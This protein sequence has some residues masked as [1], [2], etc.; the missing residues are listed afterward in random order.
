M[1]GLNGRQETLNSASCAVNLKGVMMKIKVDYIKN[2]Y[3][4]KIKISQ[5]GKSISP[6]NR[7][8]FQGLEKINFPD[9]REG[10]N[11]NLKKNIVDDEIAERWKKFEHLYLNEERIKKFW[12]AD[13]ENSVVYPPY[14]IVRVGNMIIKD[15][16]RN[17]KMLQK[18][19]HEVSPENIKKLMHSEDFEVDVALPEASVYIES[20]S[21]LLGCGLFENYF[22][23]TLRYVS[24]IQVY[25]NAEID[26]LIVPE[27]TKK[28]IGESL[29][30]FNVSKGQ[31]IY[32]DKI[33]RVKKLTISS[34]VALGR[35]EIS[36]QI[37]LNLREH[38]S[39]KSLLPAGDFKY[40]YIPRRNVKIR[41]IIN[42]C[43]VDKYFASIGF[44]IFDNSEYSIAEQIAAFKSAAVVVSVHGAG[45]TNIVYCRPN[46]LV[47]ELVPMGYDQ[48]MTSYRSLADLFNLNY[49]QLFASEAAFDLKG[50]RCNSDVSL[51]LNKLSGII[52]S[53][54]LSY[55]ENDSKSS[56]F[57]G[58][59]LGN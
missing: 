19:L 44:K 38:G 12:I 7:K 18:L 27:P 58:L 57:N 11:I 47:I 51:D 6:E 56:E 23:W 41:K 16:I 55:C 35:Y 24:K 21:F 26:K 25:Q 33:T 31:L 32:L 40:L 30:F 50:N 49:V 59:A 42:E 13:L 9:K 39:V 22:N 52:N 46:T 48:G 5:F 37:C 10:N 53:E 15:T 29:D 20:S 28:Y 8:Y 17:E 2:I 54:I 43:E 45:L 1:L 3:K 36:P 14:G 4:E 34:P